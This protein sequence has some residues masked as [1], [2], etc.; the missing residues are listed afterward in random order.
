MTS[1]RKAV[2]GVRLQTTERELSSKITNYKNGGSTILKT[3]E[4]RTRVMIDLSC[5]H[6]REQHNGMVDKTKSKNLDCWKC[7]QLAREIEIT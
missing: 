7:Q 5:G 2:T 4:I 6:S 1:F 3:I